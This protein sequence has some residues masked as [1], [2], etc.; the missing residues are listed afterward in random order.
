MIVPD[1]TTEKLLSR[2]ADGA[3]ACNLCRHGVLPC[4]DFLRAV[5][6]TRKDGK[7]KKLIRTFLSGTGNLCLLFGLALFCLENRILFTRIETVGVLLVLLC[8]CEFFGGLPARFAAFALIGAV[9]F[10]ADAAFGSGDFLYNRL[11]V[12]AGLVFL[13][14]I[15]D[16]KFRLS[17]V[18]LNIAFAAEA[19]QAP[20][21]RT[22]LFFAGWIAMNAAFVSAM[23]FLSRKRKK[24]D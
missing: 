12:W 19:V 14:E 24:Y 21:T 20:F 1:K 3:A 8:A 11:F 15:A 5:A 6:L 23:L 16:L 17:P 7:W 10:S 2:P 18:L 9:V 4:F 13:H 22:G